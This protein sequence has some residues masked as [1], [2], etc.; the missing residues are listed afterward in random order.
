MPPGLPGPP[1]SQAA[2]TRPWAA[3]RAG[4]ARCTRRARTPDAALDRPHGLPGARL[5]QGVSARQ[6]CRLKHPFRPD[7]RQGRGGMAVVEAAKLVRENASYRGETRPRHRHRPGTREAAIDSCQGSASSTDAAVPAPWSKAARMA[8]AS[9]SVT[10]NM[11][12]G[13]RRRPWP[14]RRWVSDSL[15]LN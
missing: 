15:P 10:T 8:A 4:P 2:V 6:R 13:G 9:A 1:R 12:A 5:V 14:A 11:P 3:D 7:R